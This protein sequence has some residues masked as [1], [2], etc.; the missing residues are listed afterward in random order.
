VVQ[1]DVKTQTRKVIAFLHP[2]LH[3]Q[4]G[5]VTLGTFGSAISPGGG[6]LYVTWNGNCGTK[7]EDL[8]RRAQFNTCALTV[9][10]IPQAERE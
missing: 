2:L 1:Y 10:H 5:Y 3:E 6:K 7:K 9:I 4:A 8:G